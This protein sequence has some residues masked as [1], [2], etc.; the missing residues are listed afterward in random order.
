M[1]ESLLQ[2]LQLKTQGR[3]Q[4]TPRLRLWRWTTTTFLEQKN[5]QQSFYEVIFKDYLNGVVRKST[6]EGVR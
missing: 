1:P 5:K 4:K 2:K 6:Q 3:A